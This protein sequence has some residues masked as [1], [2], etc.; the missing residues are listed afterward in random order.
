MHNTIRIHL[1][2]GSFVDTERYTLDE[3]VRVRADGKDVEVGGA[4]E[5]GGLARFAGEKPPPRRLIAQSR[6]TE[7]AELA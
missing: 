6:I 4:D 7:F 2:D 1:T 3:L 5:D